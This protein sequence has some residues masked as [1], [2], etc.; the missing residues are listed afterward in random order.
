MTG[1]QRQDSGNR[2]SETGGRQE[3]GGGR[4]E[5]GDRRWETGGGRQEVGHRR[6]DT[7]DRRERE[8]DRIQETWGRQETIKG[9]GRPCSHIKSGCTK[10]EFCFF[11]IKNP[12]SL[13]FAQIG[14]FKVS[15]ERGDLEIFLKNFKCVRSFPLQWSSFEF[16]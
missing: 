9:D 15:S 7:G 4:Q 14:L 16:I 13:H 8:K 1:D 5:A 11:G 6:W 10:I 12:S 2:R 3:T